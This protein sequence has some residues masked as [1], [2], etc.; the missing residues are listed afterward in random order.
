MVHAHAGWPRVSTGSFLYWQPALQKENMQ[1]VLVMSPQLLL[2][3]AELF[4]W[5]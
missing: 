1:M 4:S 5:Y 2:R 3:P